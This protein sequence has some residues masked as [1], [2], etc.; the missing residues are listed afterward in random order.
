MASIAVELTL[1]EFSLPQ[2]S[3]APLTGESQSQNAISTSSLRRL[4][5][6]EQE[7]GWREQELAESLRIPA[8]MGSEIE[9]ANLPRADGGMDAWLFLAGCFTIEALVWGESECFFC[10][11]VFIVV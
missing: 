2:E 7:Y 5:L 1:T 4:D 3:N 10:R 9:Q 11:R 6:D 8:N